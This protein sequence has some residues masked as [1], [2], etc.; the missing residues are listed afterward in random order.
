MKGNK[1]TFRDFIKIKQLNFITSV[2]LA[3][4]GVFFGMAPYLVTY[5]L[6]M[7]ITQ[8]NC[9]INQALV[10]VG[11]MVIC[12]ILQLVFHNVSTAISHNTAF[13]VIEK[14]RL[15]LTNKLSRMPL[16]YTQMKGNGYFK[17]LIVDET[18]R[19]E[20]PL[21]HALPE[22]I[23]NVLLPIGIIV[24][25][26][27][28]DWRLGLAAL[29]PVIVTLALYFPFYI[30]IMNQFAK[31]YYGSLDNMNS[32]VIEYITGI[33]EIKIFGRDKDLY[34]KYEDSI[35][36][37]ESSTLKLYGKMYYVSAPTYVLLVSIISSMLCFGG[38]LYCQHEITLELYMMSIFISIGIGIPLLKFIEFMD[39]FYHIK[40]GKR[41]IK[42]VMVA[43]ELPQ[44]DKIAHIDNQEIKFNNVSF[45]YDEETVL[46][47]MSLTFKAK[48]KT[49]LI[50]PSG[51][52]KTTVAN[53]MARFWDVSKGSITLGGVDIRDIPL[54]QLM[55]NISY[56]TQDTF[57][58]NTTVK[59]NIRVGKPQA[60][61]EEI[62]SAAKAA[63]CEEF[64][65]NL[66]NGYETIVGDSGSNLS[67]GQRQRIIIARAILKNNPILI[68]DEAT[69]YA[70]ME[71]Q[72]KI[73]KSLNNLCKDKTLII[74]AH[75]LTTV[76]DCD[77]IILIEN[78]KV[79]SYGTHDELIKS[80]NLYKQ[81]WEIHSSNIKW[82]TSDNKGA[83][84]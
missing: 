76:A 34:S 70:D 65:N 35:N 41:L 81:M 17:N 15:T 44:T 66:E 72:N 71:N 45:A 64:I 12:F 43:P 63:Q 74:I 78:G 82:S 3:I 47:N 11:I 36:N 67:T 8:E 80:S 60:T 55:E 20:Y 54:S 75:R 23:S 16:G 62:I 5:K 84:K 46:D 1:L 61:D 31:T 79:D 26:F 77:K 38:L 32:K 18:E 2:V 83:I 30:G 40:N 53:L 52:G 21:A 39:N 51:S 49:A 13:E 48:Q 6:L 25:L 19:L 37:Y 27:V 56:V 24:L 7:K 33:K 4:L 14:I 29:V 28:Q 9:T 69:A 68:L 57:L 50:G 73:Q 59:E 10:H 42:E 58:F 22:V